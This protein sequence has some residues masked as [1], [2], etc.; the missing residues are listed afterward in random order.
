MV[1]LGSDSNVPQ[2]S[3]ID[4]NH[5]VVPVK[6]DN[7]LKWGIVGASS[8]AR[9]W[10]INAINAQ[11]D[12]KV[13]AV[14]SSSQERAK[15]YA[16][17]TG[18]PKY[19]S[20]LE[21]FLDDK[22]VEAVY[23]GSRNDQHKSQAI[24]AARKGKHVLCDKPLALRVQD[25][26][27]MIEACAMAK[28]VFG[29]NHH[30]RSATVQRKL[31]GLV[32]AGA[33]GKPLAARAFFAVHLPEESRGWRTAIPEAGAGVVLDITVHV[34]DTL[35]FVLDDDVQEVVALTTNQGMTAPGIEDGVMGVMRF[36]SGVLAQF[37]DSFSIAHD[38]TGLQIHG[39]DGSLYAEQNMLQKPNGRL[40][41]QRNGKREE[42]PVGTIENHY[43]HL[44]HEF[45][46]A[47]R[48]Q[49][50]P[51]A[52]GEDGLKSLTIACAILESARLHRAVTVSP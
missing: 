11:P 47:V 32:K 41:L 13:V 25:A 4:G 3:K 23:I 42:V 44:L 43:E 26:R 39:T 48:G 6:E 29:T 52:T 50:K 36:R 21:S 18:I 33:I 9:S 27:E 19:Y 14:Y 28:V 20:S 1:Q 37:H 2:T 7:I 34:A 5:E 16:E 15:S 30:L 46:N 45:I 12:A 40:Y 51:F 31:R 49:G 8:I 35:R 10:M 17:E 38:L 24:A 22:D